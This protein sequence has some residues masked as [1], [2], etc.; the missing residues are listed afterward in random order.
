MSCFDHVGEENDVEVAEYGRVVA[1]KVVL[2][3]AT[4]SWIFTIRMSLFL[5]HVAFN[6]EMARI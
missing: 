2:V 4:R 6:L 3:R 5:F 1:P